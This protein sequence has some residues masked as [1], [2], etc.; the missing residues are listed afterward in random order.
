MHVITSYDKKRDK[1]IGIY[2]L[3]YKSALVKRVIEFTNASSLKS[4]D[5]ATIILALQRFKE[6]SKIY[7]HTKCKVNLESRR[8]YTN[9]E[10]DA[11]VK[12]YYYIFNNYHEVNFLDDVD[13]ELAKAWDSKYLQCDNHSVHESKIGVN[14]NNMSNAYKSNVNELFKDIR[15]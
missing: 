9:K 5:I 6:P 12:M 15:V 13:I 4:V 11:L 8:D 3:E 14:L 2:Y 7:I 10:L 1:G